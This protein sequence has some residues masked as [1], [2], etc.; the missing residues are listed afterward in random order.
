M[1]R[2]RGPDRLR[3]IVLSAF[4]LVAVACQVGPGRA[5]ATPTPS[6]SEDR[7]LQAADAKLYSGDYDGAETAYL[8][9]TRDRVE[10]AASH[11]S[12][13]YAYEERFSEAVAQAQA[14]VEANPNSEALARLTRALDWSEDVQGALAAGARAVAA[15]PVSP[16]AHVFYAE[17][18]ADGG[19]FDAARSEMRHAEDIGG[20]AFVQSEIYREWANYYRDL[21]DSASELNYTQIAVKTQPGFPER[22]LD[23][24]RLDY[25][26]QRTGVAQTLSDNLLRAHPQSYRLL[27]AVADAALIGGDVQ[28]APS[29]YAAAAQV[30]P[31]GVEAAL[32]RAEVAVAVNHDPGTARDLLLRALAANPTSS[33]VYEYVRYL[34]QL[35]LGKDPAADL[36]SVAPQRPTGAASAAKEA[37]DK[38][39][40]YRA[41]LGL[42]LLQGDPSLDDAARAQAYYFLFNAA[43]SSVAG[44]GASTQDPSFPGYT[45]ASPLDRAHRFG[46]TG[47]RVNEVIGHVASAAASVASWVDSV[48]HRYPVIDREAVS[49]G[50][51]QARVGSIDVAVMEVGA[52]AP[53]TG[54]AVVF[55]TTDQVDAPAAFVGEVPEPVPSGASLPAG[56]PVTLQVGGAQKLAVSSGQLFDAGGKAVPAFTLNPGTGVGANQWALVPRQPLRAGARYTVDVSG[57]VDGAAFTKRWSFTVAA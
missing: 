29:L 3:A 32:G 10:G 34:D 5:Q 48:F 12:T 8:A 14:G 11:L 28:R 2:M 19:R 7:R 57:T 36:G 23:L 40:S 4:V 54:D 9:L 30:Q 49:A 16:L 21:H 38:L 50:F 55:P 22:A 39:N 42:P 25:A 56:A 26:D 13:L 52:S 37:L 27:V 18:L 51:G 35:V 6:S 17:A 41:A 33:P 15:R 45:G 44:A 24:I 53:A 43:Q 20:D 1:A 47:G 46:Y 31:T